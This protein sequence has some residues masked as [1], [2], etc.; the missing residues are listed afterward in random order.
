MNGDCS[1]RQRAKRIVF[2]I[3]VLLAVT[4]HAEEPKPLLGVFSETVPV[5]RL[6][7]TTGAAEGGGKGSVPLL[8]LWRAETEFQSGNA[9]RA[10][11]LFLDLAYAYSDDERK[12]FVWMRIAELLLGKGELKQA[13]DAADKAILLTR[14]R[15][16]AL[17]SM[18]LK[19]RIYQRLGWGAEAREIAAYLLGQ[20][21]IN[22]EASDLLTEMARADGRAGRISV[23]FSEY[24]QA[25][26]AAASDPVNVLSLRRE[27]EAL[28]NGLTGIL[29]LREVAESE[30]ESEVRNLLYLR[31]AQ[32]AV[33]KGFTGMGAFALEKASRGGGAS[34][35]LATRELAWLE[36]I[37]YYRPKIVGLVPLSGKY[38]DIG[39]SVLA[40]AEVA[41]RQLRGQEAEVFS[42][43]LLWK[44]TGGQPGRARAQFQAAAQDRSVA[45]FIGPLTGEEGQ[46]VSV[47]FNPESPPA[48]YLGQK[49][50]PEKP[51]FYRF[52]LTP[53]QEA[54]AV[55][56]YLARAGR[57]DLVLFYP[58]NG[59][60]RGFADA[61]NSAAGELRI[62][63]GRSVSY[64]PDT[65][66]F[67]VAIRQGFG[68]AAL[69]SRYSGK[70]GGE[71][72]HLS[73]D[74]I[75]IADRWEKVFLLASQLRFYNVYLPLAG[76][77][78]WSDE[79]LL[80]K[81]GEAV[82]GSVFS[83]D[84]AG[85][86][87]GFLGEKFRKEYQEATE[88]APSRFEAIGYDAALL[89]AESFH[90][91]AERDSQ[92]AGERTREKIP[93][94][95]TFRGVT[96]TFQFGPAGEMR[97]KVSLLGVELGNFVPIADP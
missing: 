96:G 2:L 67:T 75:V 39:F 17:S 87:P 71:A 90:L 77:S 50:I 51:F 23:A 81:A 83:V 34:G 6:D 22:E 5:E 28:I 59:Y 7:R 44:D 80:H 68:S 72:L 10:L 82:E 3:A 32:V 48:L 93:I 46:S 64:P 42:P 97:R 38:A 27:R 9:A 19:Y 21:Y 65:S 4:A 47:A 24:R 1:G 25:I 43:V 35:E 52:G 15:F 61:V 95:G 14:A 62:R 86:L 94:L 88:R 58:D 89:L 36:R 40:G 41:L 63:V 29:A 20:G 45:G 56:S 74:A 33:R 76:F 91:D 73:Q 13:L 60:G 92:P 18:D 12:G 84:Y 53:L 16:L 26:A 37:L 31:L 8:P 78:G 79:R 11:P 70:K 30:E 57:D 49:I 55:L 66:D 69:S 54:L 85:A